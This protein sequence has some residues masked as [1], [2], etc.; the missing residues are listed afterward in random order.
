MKR[1]SDY[2]SLAQPVQVVGR[3]M[4][5]KYYQRGDGI[6]DIFRAIVKA[7]K[8][9]FQKSGIKE[10][11]IGVARSTAKSVAES[12]KQY[13]KNNKAEILQSVNELGKQAGRVAEEQLIGGLEDVIAGKNIKETAKTRGK[14]IG[15]EVLGLSKRKGEEILKSQERKIIDIARQEKAKAQKRF[16]KEGSEVASKLESA[17][18]QEAKDAYSKLFAGRGHNGKGLRQVGKKGK[19]LRQV[20]TGHK[21]RGRK[22]K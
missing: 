11:A 17:I 21:K 9:I 5:T 2:Y 4:N 16:S 6:G 8:R 3:G 1:N 14:M 15:E 13:I 20:G 12:G 22:K 19:G 10:K 18:S 7:G